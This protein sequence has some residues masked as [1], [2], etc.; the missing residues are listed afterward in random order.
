MGEAFRIL[1]PARVD[2]IV[3]AGPACLTFQ[4]H[5]AN[6]DA[7]ENAVFVGKVVLVDDDVLFHVERS[8][9]DVSLTGSRW[10]RIRD[11]AAN[12]KRVKGRVR[13]EAA[14]RGQRPPLIRIPR[15]R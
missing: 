4:L 9:P 1:L 10:R 13:T 8:L 5:S 14:R 11:F 3:R 6:F 2:D 15:Y 12:Q 7:Y